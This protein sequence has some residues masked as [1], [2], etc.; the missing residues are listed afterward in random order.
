[1]EEFRLKNTDKF[2]SLYREYESLVRDKGMDCKD[3]EDKADDFTGNRLRM[4][5]Q[6]RNY[7]SHQNDPGFLDVSSSQL[8]F[9][10]KMITDLVSE[11]DILKKHVKSPSV[12]ICNPTDKCSD[13]L[14][15]FAKLKTDKFVVLTAAGY[16]YVSLYDVILKFNEDKKCKISD[17]KSKKIRYILSSSYEWSDVPADADVIVCTADGTADGKLV[18]VCYR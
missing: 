9:L 11:H 17:V 13:V 16:E 8:K 12:S 15:R 5:R 3:F 14:G 4:C 18:G 7:L 10:E 2:L 6:F 1:M